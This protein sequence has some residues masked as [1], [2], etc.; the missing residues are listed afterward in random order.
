[1][2]KESITVDLKTF[3]VLELELHYMDG[4]LVN[5]QDNLQDN[6][7]V[8]HLVNHLVNLQDNLQWFQQ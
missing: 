1:M 8:N 4:L 7:L 3:L 2:T 6:R 5:L